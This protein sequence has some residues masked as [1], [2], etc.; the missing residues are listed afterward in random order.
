MAQGLTTLLITHIY[1]PPV[2]L[3]N[4]RLEAMETGFVLIDT[5]S[6]REHDAYSQLLKVKE[7]VELN[8][9][10]GEY[11]ILAKVEANDLNTLGQVVV[12]KIRA[13][14]GVMDTKTLIGIK[15]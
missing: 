12:D 10:F 4:E 13:V 1:N 11:D 3:L 6:T 14:E 2:A 5:L 15:F 8:V 7:I 9:L